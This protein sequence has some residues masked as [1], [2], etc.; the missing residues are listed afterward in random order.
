[1]K[2]IVTG[3]EP[4]LDNTENPSSEILELLPKSIYGNEI[5]TIKLPVIYDECFDILKLEI[6][7]HKPD[8][9]INIGLAA[10]RK[11]ISIER[12]ALNINDSVHPDNLGNIFKD[13]KI[14]EKGEAAYF[15]KLPIRKIYEKLKEKNIP[16]EIS[17]TAGLFICN[18]LMYHVLNYI[19]KNNLDIIAGFI[20]VPLMTEQV[21]NL[22]VN[23]LPLVIIL[24]G[25]IDVIK[26]CL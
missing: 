12:V 17:N 23:S 1:M 6:M 24:E 22:S 4:F 2:I 26:E 10:G 16:V 13:K 3:F 25:I 8:V 7:K 9:I 5:I 19:D 18:N 20:H 14:I 21:E 15:S 11:A